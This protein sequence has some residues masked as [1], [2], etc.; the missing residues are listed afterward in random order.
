MVMSPVV[1]GPRGVGD[2][3]L[4]TN[5]L[6]HL[7]PDLDCNRPLTPSNGICVLKRP[8]SDLCGPVCSSQ[9]EGLD[10]DLVKD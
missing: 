1:G 9:T 8:Q 10:I 4:F 5:Y 7:L 3:R 2:T 6:A